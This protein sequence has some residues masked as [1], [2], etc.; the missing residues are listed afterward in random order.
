MNEISLDPARLENFRAAMRAAGLA[1]DG[2]LIANG[3]L[4][5]FKSAGDHERNS[6]Y[7]LFPASRN[8]PTAGAFGCWK[9][10]FKETWCEKRRESLTDTEWRTIREGWKLADDERQRTEAERHAK[11]RKIANWILSR[12]RPARTLH[13]Y[14]TRKG[15]KVFGDVR[16]Y[17]GAL[18]LPLR[19]LDGELQSLQFIG[20]DGSK[21]FLTGGK[22]AGCFF[23]LADKQESPLVICEGYATGASIHEATGYDIA[24]AMNCGNL[25]AVSK[26]IREKF[27]AR[28]IIVCAD[29]GLAYRRGKSACTATRSSAGS[30]TTDA[31]R[32]PPPN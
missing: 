21:K 4:Q 28:E 27:P 30:I 12:S 2:Q 29:S 10:G 19:D 25:L 11:A 16:E 22:I 18:V 26:A 14:L 17:R 13:R 24:C 31:G 9:R 1:F 6:W 15:V 7:V 3:K 32:L 8:A 5:R 23:T 20:T